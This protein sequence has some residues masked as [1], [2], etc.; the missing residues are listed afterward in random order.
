MDLLRRDFEQMTVPE[1]LTTNSVNFYVALGASPQVLDLPGTEPWTARTNYLSEVYFLR[2]KRD[3]AA[4]LVWDATVYRVLT[5]SNTTP[6]ELVSPQY[7]TNYAAEGVGWLARRS[8]EATRSDMTN[9]L[10]GLPRLDVPLLSAGQPW[11]EHPFNAAL[12][13]SPAD[14]ARFSRVAGGVVHFRVTPLDSRGQPL[15]YSLMTNLTAYGSAVFAQLP[16]Q[17]ALDP[18]R[19][20]YYVV[21]DALPASLLVELGILE[22]QVAE[23]LQSLPTAEVRAEFLRQQAAKI[24]YFQQRLPLRSAPRL[25]P[26]S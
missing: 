12:G 15:Y 10:S 7:V 24:H 4:N 16:T 13:R 23:R 14:W 25:L 20:R 26:K 19:W 6:G 5:R 2:R 8:V 11:L 1:G 17:G 9:L 3:T 21:G 22:P 18:N